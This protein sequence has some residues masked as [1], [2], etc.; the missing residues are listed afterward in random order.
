VYYLGSDKIGNILEE[1]N[2]LCDTDPQSDNADDKGLPLP[3]IKPQSSS[4]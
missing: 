4:P 1:I 3:G 2:N